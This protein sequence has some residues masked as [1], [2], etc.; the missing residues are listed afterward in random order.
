MS[1]QLLALDEEK[2]RKARHL[3][4][5]I[6][7]GVQADIELNTT[8]S[9][10]RTVARLYGIDGANHAGVPLAN[11]VV[12]QVNGAGCLDRGISYWIANAA[13]ALDRTPQQIAEECARG[14][15]L[16]DLETQEPNRVAQAEEDYTN[17]ALAAISRQ[18]QRREALKEKLGLGRE[19]LKYVIVASGNI[20]ADVEQAKSAARQGAD[21]IAVIRTTA[22]SLLDY[23]PYG[24]TTEG[25]GGTYATQANFKVM[26]EALDEVS[27]EVGRYIQLVNYCSGLC[28]PEI[29]AMGALERLDMMLNDAMY[30]ILFR[31]INMDRTFADQYFSRMINAYAGIIINTGEDNYLTT[32]DAFEHAHTVLASNFINEQM[33][34]AAGLQNWQLGL[35]HAF[36]LDPKMK[37]GFLYELATA[38]T[39]RQIFP[40]APLKY[41]PP[42]K[43][44]TG[45]IFMGHVQNAMFNLASVMTGQSIHLLGMLTEAIHTPHLSDRIL[46]IEN[47]QYVMEN[48]RDL[49]QEISF[50]PDGIIQQRSAAILSQVVDFLTEIEAKGLKRAI[51]QGYFADIKRPE[52]GGKGGE[53]VIRKGIDYS[54]PF[55]NRMQQEL[56]IKTGAGK[57][58]P[59]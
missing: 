58:R 43:Y 49:A 32:A 33:G 1:N 54:N 10:E 38:Q 34:L 42:T 26:R 41:M 40:E 8:V 29:A 19:P 24:T 4:R 48:A 30:G 15:R 36:E 50:R 39:I 16:T 20:F 46:S 22:Q 55:M 56:G 27:E 2:V 45:D 44:M 9:V 23:V 18:R 35:G 12:D 17:Q 31:D 47:A 6:A 21:I 7:Q 53:G 14:L 3:A 57:G 51:S 28:M 5:S 11:V 37:N 59:F 52:A 13:V 25:F